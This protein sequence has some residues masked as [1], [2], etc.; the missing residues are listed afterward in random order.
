MYGWNKSIDAGNKR[1]SSDCDSSLAFLQ[2]TSKAVFFCLVSS[3]KALVSV[4]LSCIILPTVVVAYALNFNLLH[5]LSA[6]FVM[7]MVRDLTISD[8]HKSL[9]CKSEF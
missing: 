7:W 2:L 8:K 4:I 6:R 1:A 5:W 3:S 9:T